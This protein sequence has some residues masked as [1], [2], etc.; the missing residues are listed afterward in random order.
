ML[1]EC[2]RTSLLARV[3]KIHTSLVS[4]GVAVSHPADAAP[5]RYE[6][7]AGAYDP[8][9]G[10]RLRLSNGETLFSIGTVGVR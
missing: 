8:Q 10:R 9:T 2:A 7:R 6:V 1:T 3:S 4:A 5:G